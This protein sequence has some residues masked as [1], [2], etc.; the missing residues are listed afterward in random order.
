MM[1]LPVT[2]KATVIDGM[3]YRQS[4]AETSNEDK[5][6]CEWLVERV[7]RAICEVEYGSQDAGWDNQIPA[8]RAAIKA[9]LKAISMECGL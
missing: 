5:I 8:A 6:E 9:L 4:G 2:I 3:D 7:A 1:K